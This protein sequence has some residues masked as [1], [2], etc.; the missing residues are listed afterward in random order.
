M[1]RELWTYKCQHR[2]D[3]NGTRWLFV[4]H[5]VIDPEI[6]YEQQTYELYFR[7]DGW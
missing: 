1:I 2:H 6:A 3:T 7:N 4:A 5:D